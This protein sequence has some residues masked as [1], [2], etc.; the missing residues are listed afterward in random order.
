MMRS[1]PLDTFRSGP[2]KL[3]CASAGHRPKLGCTDQVQSRNNALEPGSFSTLSSC[4]RTSSRQTLPQVTSNATKAEGFTGSVHGV[5]AS[6]LA[7]CIQASAWT[8]AVHVPTLFQRQPKSKLSVSR[9][10]FR[11][12]VQLLLRPLLPRND[13]RVNSPWKRPTLAFIVRFHISFT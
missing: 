5:H 3:E 13:L 4:E 6:A 8:N 11:Q 10:V 1:S 12:R 9:R 7:G 2:R